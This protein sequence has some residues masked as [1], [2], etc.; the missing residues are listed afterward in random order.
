MSMSARIVVSQA[1]IIT[2]NLEMTDEHLLNWLETQQNLFDYLTPD[3]EDNLE[4]NIKINSL[5]HRNDFDIQSIEKSDGSKWKWDGEH[6][7]TA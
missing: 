2:A 1:L 7:T 5:N 3:L 4:T 6:L